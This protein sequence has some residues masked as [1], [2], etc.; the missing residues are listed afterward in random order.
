MEFPG[1][2]AELAAEFRNGYSGGLLPPY[3]PLPPLQSALRYGRRFRPKHDCSP[4]RT[5]WFRSGVQTIMH[6]KDGSAER[7]PSKGTQERI[8]TFSVVNG[9]SIADNARELF[10]ETLIPKYGPNVRL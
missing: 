2:D 6:G 10:Y 4:G 9:G 7:L 5:D 1:G 3:L 8:S